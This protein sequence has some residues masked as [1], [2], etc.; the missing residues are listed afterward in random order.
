MLGSNMACTG[1]AKNISSRGAL[2]GDGLA[3]GLARYNRVSTELD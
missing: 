1:R 2:I 3:I